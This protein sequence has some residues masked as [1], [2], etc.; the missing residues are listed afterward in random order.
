MRF[1]RVRAARE[2]SQGCFRTPS[3][4]PSWPHPLDPPS[5][6]PLL[7]LS[8]TIR[9]LIKDKVGS[10]KLE[11]S[12]SVVLDSKGRIPSV[13]DSSLHRSWNSEMLKT[14]TWS[15]TC[16][17]VFCS[18][19]Q[20]KQWNMPTNSMIL[21]DLFD[22]CDENLL[23]SHHKSSSSSGSSSSSKHRSSSS[24]SHDKSSKDHHRYRRQT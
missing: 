6:A 1:A 5:E 3:D 14:W 24:S 2:H 17:Y 8:L 20:W 22:D 23:Q 7:S 15:R 13:Q 10:S 19:I 12:E 9:L 21:F 11:F 18:V 16:H 4:L